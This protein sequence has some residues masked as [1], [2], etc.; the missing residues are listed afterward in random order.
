MIDTVINLTTL[1]CVIIPIGK[2]VYDKIRHSRWIPEIDDQVRVRLTSET[3]FILSDTFGMLDCSPTPPGQYPRTGVG[4]FTKD[5]LI[6]I[7]KRPIK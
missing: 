5:A 1:I 3:L 4:G 2:N 6:L 7:K